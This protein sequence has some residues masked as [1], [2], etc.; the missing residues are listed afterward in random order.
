MLA[1]FHVICLTGI[2]VTP[3]GKLCISNPD[4]KTVHVVTP[5]GRLESRFNTCLPALEKDFNPWGLASNKEGEVFVCDWNNDVIRVFD[6]SGQECRRFGGQGQE[7]GKLCNP[8]DLAVTP[9]GKVL[10][11]DTDNHRIQVR[12]HRPI[13]T[14][15]YQIGLSAFLFC[16]IPSGLIFTIL[17]F[18]NNGQEMKPFSWQLVLLLLSVSSLENV[19]PFL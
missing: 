14:F 13:K 9:D 6:Q 12:C 4:M 18:R 7:P 15:S 5:E 17:S 10:V 2:C 11:A 19:D 16:P 3:N 1:V 8:Q